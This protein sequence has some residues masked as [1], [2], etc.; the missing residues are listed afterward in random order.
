MRRQ[1][2]G[3]TWWGRA[4]VRALEGRARLD[5]NRLPRGRSYAREN[6]VIELNVGPGGVTAFVQGRQRSPYE[7]RLDVRAF[8]ASEWD[9]VV[10]AIAAKAGHAAALFAGELQPEILDDAASV[11]VDLLPDAGELVPSCTCADWAD[12]CKHSAAVCYLVADV[13]DEDPFQ[14]FHLRGRDR[15]ALLAAVRAARRSTAATASDTPASAAVDDVVVGSEAGA[16]ARDAY[17]ASQATASDLWALDVVHPPERPGIPARAAISPPS[18]SGVHPDELHR[19]AVDAAERAWG[20]AIGAASSGLDLELDEDLGR[21]T[22]S[23]LGTPAFATLADRSG[24]GRGE[25]AALGIAWEHGERE[26]VEV[27]RR[28]WDAPDDW[29]DEG[30]RALEGNARWSEPQER[31]DDAGVRSTGWRVQAE[32]NRL[33]GRGIQLRVGPSGLWYRFVESRGIWQLD[34]PPSP[35]PAVLVDEL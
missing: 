12:P 5:A 23:V 32:G 18:G 22:S 33:D 13:L 10:G 21:L 11:G 3:G 14:L 17:A 20:L 8:T 16:V 4:W 25:L 29:L 7:V 24:V 15:R 9:A 6:R 19:L 28:T 35:D 27:T 34:G 30:R 1:S 26:G 2:F 31:T